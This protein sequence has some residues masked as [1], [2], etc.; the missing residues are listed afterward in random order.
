[1][2]ELFSDEQATAWFDLS[3]VGRAAARLDFDKLA[4]VNAHW[5]RLADD[6]R[7]AKLT[8]DVHLARGHRLAPDDEARLLRAMPFVKDRA[9]TT[10]ELAHQT[11][12]VLKTR[13]L[14]IEA[15]GLEQLSGEAGQRIG[16]LRDRLSLF[17]SWDVFALEAELKAFAEEEGVGFGKIGPAARAAL[18]GGSTSPDIAKTLAALGR[19]ESLGRL[20]DALQQ[21]I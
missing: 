17:E 19:E 15:R 11:A 16:R 13:P 9:K 5:I 20:N 10:L 8:L 12:F 14:A 2:D 21:T 18:A 1:D 7:L 4:H 6:D 3:G